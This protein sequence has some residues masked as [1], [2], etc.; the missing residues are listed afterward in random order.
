MDWIRNG[1]GATSVAPYSVRARE[2]LPVSM[3]ISWKELDSITPND[4]TMNEAIARLRRK[5]PWDG[6]FD[7][8]LKLK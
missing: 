6:F 3:P 7:T 8:N 1:R 2:G 5:N 4:I